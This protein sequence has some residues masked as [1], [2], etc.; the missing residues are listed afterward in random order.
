M[1]NN[2]LDKDKFIREKMFEDS[3]SP[4]R[5]YMRLVIGRES[6]PGLLKYE[7]VTCLLGPL[8]G[9]LGLALRKIFYPCLFPK[10]GKGVVFGRNVT[11]R[12]PQAIELGDNVII[13]D[14]ALLDGRVPG[15][16][17]I[18]IGDKCIIGRHATLTAKSGP[19]VI[20]DNCS[21]GASSVISS[22]GGIFIE[23]WVQMAGECK[24]VGGLFVFNESIKNNWKFKR[25]SKGSI[26]IGRHSFLG[27]GASVL[28]NV[29]I[30]ECCLIGSGCVVVQDV[31]AFSTFVPRPGMLIGKHAPSLD[32]DKKEAK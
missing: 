20:G 21:I 16:D 30:G 27:G 5:K 26:A 13:D 22:Q 31:P 17:G 32:P 24:I 7:L 12:N 1:E 18:R 6:I 14:Y 23:D 4:L 29:T 19:I 28:D 8:P 10:I 2:T 15:E 3:S 25:I 9:A 11:I